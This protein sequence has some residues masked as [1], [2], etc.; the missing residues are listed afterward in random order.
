MLSRY[1]IDYAYKRGT[2]EKLYT[3]SEGLAFNGITND[4]TIVRYAQSMLSSNNIITD[5]T[6]L[7]GAFDDA[8]EFFINQWA[9]F[10]IW[11]DKRLIKLTWFDLIWFGHVN[12]PT[13]VDRVMISGPCETGTH[14][15]H[16][17]HLYFIFTTFTIVQPG[18]C[19]TFEFVVTFNM[20]YWCWEGCVG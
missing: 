6:K 10:P 1:L 16:D 2:I 8:R 20:G 13:C 7:D 18:N 3:E 19:W 14:L 17:T 4:V 12:S 11:I 9:W 15:N 5:V